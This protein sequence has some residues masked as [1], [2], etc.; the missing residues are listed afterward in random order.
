MTIFLSGR[1][2]AEAI[3]ELIAKEEKLDILVA[4]VGDGVE[5]EIEQRSSDISQ[6]RLACNLTH[7]ATNP[8]PLVTLLKAGRIRLFQID[9]LHAKVLLGSSQA[10]VSSANASTRALGSAA[11]PDPILLEAGVKITDPQELASIRSWIERIFVSAE[12]ITDPEHSDLERAATEFAVRNVGRL[13]NRNERKITSLVQLLSVA[14]TGILDE[15]RIIAWSEDISDDGYATVERASQTFGDP[16]IS[17]RYAYELE[18]RDPLGEGVTIIDFLI[19]PKRRSVK[20]GKFS[21]PRIGAHA[22]LPMRRK[23]WHI[24][25][26]D[27]VATLPGGISLDVATMRELGKATLDF[28]AGDTSAVTSLKEVLEH[29]KTHS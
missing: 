24:Q 28:L 4:Y 6:V 20:P 21:C 3:R 13:L 9:N 15:V 29:R 26:V 22:K 7:G 27:P 16:T 17:P 19:S 14:E 1:R 25:L 2:L 8:K 5:K 10:I 11:A 23:G 18:N 12:E